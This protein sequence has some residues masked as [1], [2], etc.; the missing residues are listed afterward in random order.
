MNACVLVSYASSSGSTREI[1]T[2]VAETLRTKELTVDLEPMRA[3]REMS[4]YS[5]VVLGIP[6]YLLRW[7][8]DARRFLA[9]HQALLGPDR[10]TAVFT[11][12]PTQSGSEE[13]WAG[14]RDQVA[15]EISRYPWFKPVS[16][17]FVGGRLDP[18]HL[19]FPYN[20]LP[21]LRSQPARDLRDWAAIRAWATTLPDLLRARPESPVAESR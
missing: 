17:E 2:V 3:V 9:R 10:P 19:P 21:A 12:G 6:L 15:Q 14:V 1:A 5:A 8:G 20:L 16:I 4:R 18:D 11:G 7:H 13:E